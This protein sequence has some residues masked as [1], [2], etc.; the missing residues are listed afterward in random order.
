MVGG[1]ASKRD[2]SHREKL[3]CDDLFMGGKIFARINPQLRR[4]GY[5]L[6]QV[7]PSASRG[8]GA[9]LKAI[10]S[11]VLRDLPQN[12]QR[13]LEGLSCFWASRVSPPA[14]FTLL[15]HDPA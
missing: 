6:V 8:R 11:E 15:G 12:P 7:Q 3:L 1:G 9:V 4:R 13:N 14:L 2:K 10:A 5:L